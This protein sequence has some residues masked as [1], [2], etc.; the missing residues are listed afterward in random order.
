MQ[1]LDHA[2]G[3]FPLE[4]AASAAAI[5]DPLR[6]FLAVDLGHFAHGDLGSLGIAE[7]SNAGAVNFRWRACEYDALCLSGGVE[8]VDVRTSYAE[9][10]ASRRIIIRSWVKSELRPTSVELAPERRVKQQRHPQ[11]ISVE[12]NG[13]IHVADKLD[14]V[15]EAH[16]VLHG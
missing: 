3:S 11:R 1:I 15:I 8:V 14:H 16:V 12:A 5:F 7:T 10:D 4:P 9:L 6:T 13:G 2:N